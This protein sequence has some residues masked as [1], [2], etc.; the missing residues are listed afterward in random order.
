MAKDAR[1]G[2][3]KCKITIKIIGLVFEFI[4]STLFKCECLNTGVRT[5]DITSWSLFI[6]FEDNLVVFKKE[7]TIKRH[8]YFFSPHSVK[9][10]Q[11]IRAG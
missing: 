1:Q 5:L 6:F 9:R 11:R 7:K 10:M 3:R 4:T 2:M 8:L